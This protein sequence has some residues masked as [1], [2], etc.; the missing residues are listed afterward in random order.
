M[1]KDLNK[2]QIIGR[3]GQDPET[4]YTPSGANDY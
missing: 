1:A 2:V 3:L 4:R